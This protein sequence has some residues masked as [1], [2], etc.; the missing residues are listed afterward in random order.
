M[1]KL[2][3]LSLLLIFT[4]VCNPTVMAF[5][6]PPWD[7]GHNSFTGDPGDTNTDPGTCDG[8]CGKC[9]CTSKA[10]SPVEAA[11]GNFTYTLRV[12]LIS[13]LGPSLD[14]VLT[15][16]TQDRH[17]GPFGVGWVNPYEQ[18]I[19]ETTDGTDIFAIYSLAD[20]KR[21]RFKRNQDGTYVTPP[22]LFDT[23]TK[24]LD[25]T[26]ILR[27]KFGIVRR[28]SS[29]GQLTAIVDRNGNTLTLTYDVAGF[30]TK[31]TDASGR[32][33]AV[34]KGADGRVETM[35]D[36]ANR[37]FRFAY[38]TS[39]NLT[40]YTDPVGT[41]TTYQYDSANNMTAMID[42]R[43]NTLM[44]LTY[45]TTGR[46]TQHVDGAETWT[47][48]Y[49]PSTKR[50]TKRDSQGRT[51][52]FDYGDNGNITKVTDPLGKIDQYVTDTN[53]TVTQH[54]NKNGNTTKYTYDSVGNRRTVT[55]AL[56]NVWRFSYDPTFNQPLTIQDALGNTTRL[57]YD[58]SG[59]LTKVTNALGHSTQFQ[60]DTKGQLTRITDALGN[61]SNRAYDNHGNLIQ[62]KDAL[63][64]TGTAS[65][66]IIGRLLTSTDAEGRTTQFVYDDNSRLIRTIDAIGA[67]TINEYDASGNL[68]ALTMPGGAKTTFQYD[69]FN[70]LIR[71]TNPLGQSTSRA[72]DSQ[73][74]LSSKTD[75]KNQTITYSYDALHRLIR[76]TKPDD[77]VSYN[78]DGMGNLLNV[79]DGDSNLSYTYDVL[80]RL[81]QASTAAT[82]GQPA[83]TI[84]FS[85]DGNGDRKTMTDPSSGLTNYV[86]DA[87]RRLTSLTDPSGQQ[88]TFSYDELSRR[89]RVTRPLGLNTTY[90]YDA[91]S[92]LTSLVHQGGPGTLFFNHT[93]DRVGNRKTNSDASG[94][95]SHSYDPIYRLTAI[96]TPTG[97]ESY[98]YDAAGN[99]TTSHIS[100][101][102]SHDAVNR[103]T[104]DGTFD[105][106]YDAN[107]NLIS[108][109]ERATSKVTNYFYDSENQLIRIDFPTNTSTTYR[110]DGRGRRIEKN[111]GG[112]TTRYIY[113][114]WD[115]LFEYAG[116]TVSARYTSG[117]NID[118]AFSV[119]RGTATTH[120][121]ANSLGSVVREVDAGSVKATYVYDSFGQIITQT[122]ARQGPYGFQGREYDSESNLYYFRARYYDPRAGRFV[123]EDPIGFRGGFNLF[124]FV[125]NNPINYKDPL[126][127]KGC[128]CGEKITQV[129]GVGPLDA[130]T[131]SGLADEAYAAAAASGLPGRHNGQQDAFRHCYW[132]CRMAQEIGAGQAQTVGN[133]HEECGGNP[134]GETAM[135]LNNNAS[136]RGFGAPGAN[137]GTACMGAVNSGTLQTS[138]GGTPPSLIY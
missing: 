86:Y 44:R 16:N 25:G 50:T 106:L 66:D 4:L 132:S 76:K 67:T 52:T 62:T 38:D 81:T 45:D 51:W 79:V 33:V 31:I 55:D 22:R 64:N 108:K 41:L 116:A 107:G 77:T 124:A 68:T 119:T 36:P 3:F 121:Q 69:S 96:S 29:Q 129:G 53:L 94:L 13:G 10:M 91:A 85:Y 82:A 80:N 54:T 88:F 42:P 72:Y 84:R 126:G 137:C 48:S 2:Q 115:I 110:Y 70:R 7:T 18:R 40:R 58:S 49:S 135:D 14:V 60:Y 20:G 134:P 122:G 87:L 111:V 9:P 61:S 101:S 15:Y 57:E 105:Y 59:N 90:T 131:A 99:R 27:D 43:G 133:I 11:S 23:L 32:S 75:A 117:P 93:Y 26:F 114:G 102:Y 118:E 24:S 12:L 128:S 46:V 34:T 136:G 56:N 97:A 71:T 17:R 138:P 47:Y 127:L 130:L 78:Y 5:H 19:V 83:T 89:T 28:F 21:E 125:S 30:M 6:A 104:T 65:F 120:F 98:S 1:K 35:T 37:T 92:R 123:S 39:G 95:Q 73:D 113:E 100:A 109:S 63:G 74:N 112:Q 103:L 8:S